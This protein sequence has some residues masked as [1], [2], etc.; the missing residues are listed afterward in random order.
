MNNSHKF[1]THSLEVLGLC[2]PSS[3]TDTLMTEYDNGQVA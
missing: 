3:P 2:H 1:F